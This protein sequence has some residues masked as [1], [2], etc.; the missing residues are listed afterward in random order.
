MQR[1]LK[2]F[3]C[4]FKQVTFRHDDL[5]YWIIH[6]P[7]LRLLILPVALSE[8]SQQMFN[9]QLEGGTHGVLTLITVDR[10]VLCMK[11]NILILLYHLCVVVFFSYNNLI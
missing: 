4:H 9:L 2:K 6:T 7:Y 3:E 1:M 5:I 11:Q 8:V 10:H